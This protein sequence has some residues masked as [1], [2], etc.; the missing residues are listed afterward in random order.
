M[1]KL[2]LPL[3]LGAFLPV[4]LAGWGMFVLA[5]LL[6]RLDRNCGHLASLGFLF[7]T[8]GGFLYAG[9]K[10]VLAAAGW[11]LAVL[12]H[13]LFILFAPGFVLVAWAIWNTFQRS[14]SGTP[15]WVVPVIVIVV[16]G[17]AAAISA[18]SRGG[19]RWFYI[20]LGLTALAHSAT[21]LLLAWQA[22][23]RGV[24]LA[25]FLLVIYWLMISAQFGLLRLPVLPIAWQW[26]EQLTSTI[27]WGAF[28]YAAWQL[29]RRITRRATSS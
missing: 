3:A 2:T 1:E 14:S 7:V 25:T 19:Q 5:R 17:G 12:R 18:L 24:Q 22:A 27:A 6:A 9:W 20:L 13:S 10:L 8:L 23:R 21:A 26:M 16:G 4:F 29:E 11:D 15:V 28:A